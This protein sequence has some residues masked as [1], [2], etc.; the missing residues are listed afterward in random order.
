MRTLL[1]FYLCQWWILPCFRIFFIWIRTHT[2]IFPSRTWNLHS[3]FRQEKSAQPRGNW[4]MLMASSSHR[5]NHYLR[6]V[7]GAMIEEC[8]V[9]LNWEPS[10]LWGCEGPGG[11]WKAPCVLKALTW[12][13]PVVAN[14]YVTGVVWMP[15]SFGRSYFNQELDRISIGC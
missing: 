2:H 7:V 9:S 1:S 10:A 15:P 13:A 12:A 5:L 8:I 6:E 4:K 3:L 14:A 11:H